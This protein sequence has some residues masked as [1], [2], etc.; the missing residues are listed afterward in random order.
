MTM[1]RIMTARFVS[2]V[3]SAALIAPLLFAQAPAQ[4]RAYVVTLDPAR[5]VDATREVVE[6]MAA[7]YGGTVETVNEARTGV[8]VF[9][10]P[11]SRAR[12][13]GSDP[14]VQSMEPL[15]PTVNAAPPKEVVNWSGGVSYTY[16]GSGNVRQIGRD[17][18]AYDHAGRLIEAKVNAVVRHYGYDRFGNRKTCLQNAGSAAQSDCQG[19]TI[20]SSNNQIAE[21][22]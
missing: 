6:A 7:S 20:L 17:T 12:A 8:Y 3:L 10:L 15:A 1:K 11:A 2:I 13:L 18:F 14:R 4:E 22:T 5:A 16:D 9:R 21:A 19:F